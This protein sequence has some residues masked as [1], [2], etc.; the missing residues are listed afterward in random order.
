MVLQTEDRYL[1]TLPALLNILFRGRWIIAAVTALG[2]LA[3][4]GYGIVVKPL[5]LAAVQIRPGIV[6][7]TEQGG[8]IRGWVREDIVNYFESSLFWQDMREDERFADL[9]VPPVV[10]AEFVASAIQFM[11]G[12]DVIT[13][14]NLDTDRE[15]AGAILEGAMAA[16][17]SQGFG[18]T[19]SSDLNLT[20]KGIEVRMRGINHDI[21]LVQAKEDKISLEIEQMQGEQKLIEYERKKLDL[22]LKTL[23]EENAWRRRAAE[24]AQVEVATAKERLQAAEAMLETVL[25]TETGAAGGGDS[26]GNTNDPVGE[27]LKQ[28]ASREQAG[29]V[30]DLLLTV[31][32]L[33]NTI[34]EGGVKADSLLARVVANEQEMERLNLVGELVLAKRETDVRQRIGDLRIQLEKELPHERAMLETDLQGERV[35]LD[36]IAPLEQVGRI[37]VSDNPVRPRKMRA[38]TILTVLAFFG[39]L[40]LVFLRE[41]FLV[42]REEITRPTRI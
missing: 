37:S 2:L 32:E 15:R 23:A 6:A 11:A 40:A 38:M 39:S 21:D 31:N 14:T 20:R 42:N 7:Y 29:R 19:L 34:Y 10:R 5:Y 12:G 30:G 26:G 41:F 13:L 4:I 25:R 3:G 17:N 28:T 35:K 33:S 8:P 24:N 18:D 36:N 1:F 16:F 9:E 22:D 27:V